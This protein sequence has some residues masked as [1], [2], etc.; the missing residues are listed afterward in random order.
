MSPEQKTP[1]Q[2]GLS[3]HEQ[4]VAVELR[5]E[6]LLREQASQELGNLVTQRMADKEVIHSM[7]EVATDIELIG[8]A[9]KTHKAN[10]A[11]RRVKRHLR[12][13]RQGYEE[14]AIID[15]HE[16]GYKPSGWE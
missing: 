14:Q 1:I 10:S 7:N 12:N 6:L 3:E 13:N 16:A 8:H 11:M 9:W 4:Q 15:A 2:P 5:Q